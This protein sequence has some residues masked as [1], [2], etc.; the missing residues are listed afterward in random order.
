VPDSAAE[1]CRLTWKSSG[2]QHLVVICH[3]TPST[4]IMSY[5]VEGIQVFGEVVLLKKTPE[6]V[7]TFNVR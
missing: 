2:E 7:E 1:A 5:I 4:S 6:G 3:Q